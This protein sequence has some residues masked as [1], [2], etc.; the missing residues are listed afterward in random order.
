MRNWFIYLF[1]GTCMPV[2]SVQAQHT[3]EHEVMETIVKLFDGMREADSSAVRAAFVPG[4]TLKI[5]EE[6]AEGKM[7]MRTQPLDAFVASVGRR[8]PGE[9][10][11]RVMFEMV[12]VEG[13]L[14][15]VWAPYLFNL[16]GQLS[17]CGVDAFQLVKV[18][19][20]WKIE[21]LT[22]TIRKSDC[23]PSHWYK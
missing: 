5:I 13:K 2:M 15:S 22:Y 1:L 21:S 12:K 8:N 7:V 17:H 3:E 23:G 11:E 14:A 19:E 16:R 9:L 20:G 10:D 18:G 6:T 4:V